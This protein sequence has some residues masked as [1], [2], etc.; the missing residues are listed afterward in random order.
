M[1]HRLH[2]NFKRPPFKR[3]RIR[4]RSRPSPSRKRSL[5]RW[6]VT[7]LLFAVSACAPKL[8]PLH[9]ETRAPSSFDTV[10]SGKAN[11]DLNW[12]RLFHSSELNSLVRESIA[13]N[14][15]LSTA[16]ARFAEARA[17]ARSAG[18]SLLPGINFE[19]SAQHSVT[20]GSMSASGS[21]T[22]SISSDQYQ[23]GLTASYTVD[24]WG[25]Y[26][27][28]ENAALATALAS[29]Y[30]REALSLSIASAV[31]NTYVTLLATR[32]RLALAEKNV[33]LAS[34]IL[35]AIKARLQA[36][37]A[38]ALDVAEQESVLA[39][40]K[41]NIPP[42][43]QSARQ[44]NVQLAILMGRMPEGL[45]VT[46]KSLEALALPEIGTGLPSTLLARRPDV[47]RDEANLL[48]ADANLS[49]AR[50]AFFPDIQLTLR[51]GNESR[52]LQ[53][54]LRPDSIFATAAGSLTTPIF[55]GGQ[56]QAAFDFDKARRDELVAAYRKTML[57][58]FADVENALIAIDQTKLQEQLQQDAVTAAERAYRISE[59]R[60]R[61]G[62]IDIVTLFTTQQTLFSA[63]T[64]LVQVKQTRFQAALSLIQALGGGFEKTS[65]K[66]VNGVVDRINKTDQTL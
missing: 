62:T 9:L 34:H 33:A 25:R 59:E 35:D 17:S 66:A 11:I 19:N 47:A 46:V 61:S 29:G 53:S 1:G 30:D 58:A 55:D 13:N 37:T 26:R 3:G 40:Q 8:D 21:S 6:T 4:V 54:L 64:A 18:V 39:S 65:N 2:P 52:S 63:E 36:G 38:S 45:V 27:A 12:P 51:G 24:L 15:D 49:A 20:P 14:P 28:L 60:L 50:A 31:A 16:T 57:S 42:L 5:P 32:D 48:A 7:L 56:L 44:S 23:F 10:T 41:A 22:Q 43:Q